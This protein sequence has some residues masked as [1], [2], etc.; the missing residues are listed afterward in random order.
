MFE[1]TKIY[2]TDNQ[3]LKC[4][5]MN[6]RS[7]YTKAL[8]VNNIFTYHSCHGLLLRGAGRRGYVGVHKT[9]VFN[10]PIHMEYRTGRR[11]T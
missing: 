5:L 2:N 7:L 4:G 6:I 9:R 8:F 3:M 11:N 1:R 10:Y